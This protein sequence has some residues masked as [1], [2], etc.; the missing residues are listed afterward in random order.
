MRTRAG[1]TLLE[2]LLAVT[3]M[4]VVTSVAYMTFSAATN[5]WVRGTR[6]AEGLHH[7]DYVIDQLVMGLRS[8]YSPETRKPDE[9]YGFSIDDDGDGEQARDRI[10]WTKLGGA[11]V[12]NTAQYAGTPHRVEVTVAEDEDSGS[13]GFAVRSWRLDGHPE[14]FDPEEEVER[15]FLSPRVVGFNC[16]MKDPDQAEDEDDEIDWIDEWEFS[17]KVPYVVE[18]TLYVDPG[19]GEA[20]AVEVKRIVEIPMAEMTWNPVVTGGGKNPK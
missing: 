2:L 3:I 8:A 7:A 14:D 6:M 5:A 13:V 9:K 4:A 12:G 1:F 17:N 19:M 15:V 10:S 11:L 16:R 18:V 20:D